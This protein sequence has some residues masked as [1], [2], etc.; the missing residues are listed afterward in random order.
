MESGR[1][2]NPLSYTQIFEESCPY[3]MSIGMP[4]EEFWHGD[5]V[6]CRDY[7]RASELTQ[8]QRNNDSWWNNYYAFIAYSIALGNL[9]RDKGSNPQEYLKRPLSLTVKEAEEQK[10]QDEKERY[11][12]IK[13][14]LKRWDNERSSTR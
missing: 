8:A 7:L 2:I 10:I 11:E 3:F 6:A 4:R 13:T 1:E 5:P 9:F 14:K 12:R